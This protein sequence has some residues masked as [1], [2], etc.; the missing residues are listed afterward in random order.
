MDSEIK[1]TYFG[2][3]KLIEKFDLN[4]YIGGTIYILI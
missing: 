3:V 4:N 1:F 2:K